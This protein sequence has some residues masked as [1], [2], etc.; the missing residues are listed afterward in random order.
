MDRRKD[1]AVKAT[2]NIVL[3]ALNLIETKTAA[4]HYETSIACHIATGSD[5]GDMSHGRK[6][7]NEILRAA[8][9]YIDGSVSK[10]LQEPLPSTHL[11]PHF[12]VS[13]DKSTIHR[14]TNQA[15]MLCPLVE[16]RRCAIP[17]SASKVYSVSKE[18]EESNEVSGACAPELANSVFDS[19]KSTCGLK[20]DALSASWQGT[21]C[22]GQYY[23][24]KAFEQTLNQLLKHDNRINQF[25]DVVWD[26]P[27][28]VDKCIDDV[29]KGESS[30]VALYFANFLY[31]LI[32][33]KPHGVNSSAISVLL[34][35]CT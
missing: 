17:V 2:E 18:D 7:M 16:G 26:P 25:Y 23:L 3:V 11:P 12:Y 32:M 24:A 34:H 1:R 19:I 22:D 20:E 14:I 30:K 27:H 15:I 29:F 9:I 5:M 13:C 6:Q 10:F 35:R 21:C 4:R 8:E 31:K 33:C 28:W